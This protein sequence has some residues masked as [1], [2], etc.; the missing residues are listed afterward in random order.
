MIDDNECGAVGGMDD[1]ENR[2][3]RTKPVPVQLCPP[4]TPHVLIWDGTRATSVGGRRITA[5]AMARP[6]C[7]SIYLSIYLS[8][9]YIY[10]FTLP[11][12]W[13]SGHSSWLQI[14]MWEVVGLER[15]PL[16][17]VSTIVELLQRK[18]SGSGLETEIT[19][20]GIR[21]ADHATLL[22]PQKLT[23]T[24]PT[25]SGHFVGIVRSRTQ[26]T[27]YLLY[28]QYFTLPAYPWVYDYHWGL[29]WGGN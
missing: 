8:I 18:S 15:G 29:I 6:V 25:N 2:N 5:W 23:L 7:R 26:A 12:L 27:E 9:L 24:S 17:L 19:A 13:S 16:S 10:I 22:Y 11:P 4:Q 1:R 28:I 21:R 3:S 20:V 14:Q